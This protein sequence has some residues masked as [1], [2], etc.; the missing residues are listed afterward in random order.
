LLN[1]RTPISFYGSLP[2]KNHNT[3]IL[4]RD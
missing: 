1:P 2:I 4:P 3:H